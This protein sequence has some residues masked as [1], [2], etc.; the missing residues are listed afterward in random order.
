MK[1]TYFY[2]LL[3]VL[4]LP[5]AY[6]EEKLRIAILYQHPVNAGG[7]SQSHEQARLAID[8]LYGGKVETAAAPL[9]GRECRAP[10]SRRR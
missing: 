7:W 6:A 9:V 10:A 1:K 8:D 5:S 4:F 2:C 3:I